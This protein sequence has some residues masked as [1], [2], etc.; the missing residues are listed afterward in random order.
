[1][2]SH[3]RPRMG[4]GKGRLALSSDGGSNGR[5]VASAEMQ[6]FAN[7]IS[8]WTVPATVRLDLAL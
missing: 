2:R 1:M 7:G 6:Q 5:S 4:K 8:K 3:I